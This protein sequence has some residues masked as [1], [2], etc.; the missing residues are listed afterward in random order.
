MKI[1]PTLVFLLIVIRLNAQEKIFYFNEDGKPTSEKKAVT[2]QQ[3]IRLNDTIWEFNNYL[4]LGPL[5]VSVRTS[6]EKGLVPN[7]R[8]ISYTRKGT[9]DTMGQY[10]KGLKEGSWIVYTASGRALRELTY[11][12]GKL[13]G[14][15]DSTEMNE[16]WQK[17]HDSLTHTAGYSEA[18]SVFPGGAPAWNQYLIGHM[19]YPDRAVNNEIQG[20]AVVEFIVDKQGQIDPLDIFMDHSIEFSID[21]ESKRLIR[22]SPAWTAAEQNGKKVYSYKKQP[23]FFKLTTK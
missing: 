23:F 11:S 16:A 22:E 17:A 9:V 8:Y 15:R 2:L 5:Y 7:G 19:R 4:I 3:R 20:T 14:R 1:Y 13:V 12:N 18:E 21:K 10:Y 6:D